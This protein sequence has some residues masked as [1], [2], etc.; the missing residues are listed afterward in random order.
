MERLFTPE[1]A[2]RTLPLVKRIVKDILEQGQ[3][4]KEQILSSAPVTKPES[5]DKL[6]GLMDELEELG[7]YFKDWNFELGLVDFPAVIDGEKVFLCWRSDEP[8]VMYYHGIEE[9]YGGRREIPAE[10]LVAPVGGDSGRS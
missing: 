10:Y 9:G 4:L 2:N 7:C 6:E 5:M 3:E 1:E 8:S